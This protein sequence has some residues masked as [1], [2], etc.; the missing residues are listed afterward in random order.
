MRSWIYFKAATI[1]LNMNRISR[2]SKD[3]PCWATNC[4]RVLKYRKIAWN[5]WLDINFSLEKL[6]S[7][8]PIKVQMHLFSAIMLL[9]D[10]VNCRQGC[11]VKVSPIRCFKFKY[12]TI[13]A[14]NGLKFLTQRYQ[15]VPSTRTLH[16]SIITSNSVPQRAISHKIFQ[17]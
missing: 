5:N 3:F 10:N 1:W 7:D 16:L 6:V 8:L 14:S 17:D 2:S 13:G 12:T 9:R 4:C 15:K 11:Y